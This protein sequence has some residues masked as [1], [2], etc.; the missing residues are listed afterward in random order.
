MGLTSVL[1]TLASGCS[2]HDESAATVSAQTSQPRAVEAAARPVALP[3]VSNLARSVQEQMRERHS[4]LMARLENRT[5]PP[6][7]LADAYGELGLILMAAEYYDGIEE[8]EIG[9]WTETPPE[10]EQRTGSTNGCWAHVDWNLFR[11]GPLRPAIG[12]GGYRT[13]VD[14]LFHGGA[15]SHPGP[16]V[17][18]L[19]GRS[20]AKAVLRALR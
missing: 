3:D 4:A 10:M 9:R 15:G 2:R 8:L 18:G 17:S 20:A 7:Q 16:G 11:L 6:T 1:A 19:P 13:P 14:G 12:L 5:T